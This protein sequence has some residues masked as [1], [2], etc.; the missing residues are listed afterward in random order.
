MMYANVGG[1]K[2]SLQQD[3]AL[4]FCRKQNKDLIISTNTH[5]NHD[6]IHNWLGPIFFS[7]G[8]SHTKG[9]LIL[10]HPDLEGV[11]E[12]DIDPKRRF[13]SVNVTPFNNSFQL[14]LQGI[15]QGNNRQGGISLNDSNIVWKVKMREM[16]KK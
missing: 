8:E 13:A 4:E 14:P 3:L 1:F 2:G 9:L 6:Q 11:T 15:T 7:P 12:V 16:K 5:I 10:L